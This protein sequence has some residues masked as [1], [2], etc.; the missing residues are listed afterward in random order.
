MTTLEHFSYSPDVAAADFHLFRWLK[1]AFEG[2]C[3]CDA[4]EI[5]KN[6]TDELKRL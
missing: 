3:F 5:I 4:T 6:A 2:R 1:S